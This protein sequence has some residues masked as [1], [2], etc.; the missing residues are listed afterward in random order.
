MADGDHNG[1]VR[2]E[3]LCI[4][5]MLEGLYLCA[6]LVAVLLLHLK[7]L[8]LHHLL[9][10]FGIVKDGLEVSDETLQLLKLG[11]ELVH[12]QSGKL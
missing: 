2:I 9:A 8:V 3:V 6:A 11:M 12:T 1:V 5:L 4:K 10:K 7:Q